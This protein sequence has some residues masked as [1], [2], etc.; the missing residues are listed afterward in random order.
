MGTM[1]EDV[2]RS[3][4][5][6]RG[7]TIIPQLLTPVE[8]QQL[9]DVCLAYFERNAIYL[10]CGI[11]QPDA[12][13]KIPEI[14]W[15]LGDERIRRIFQRYCGAPLVYC[16]HSD[17]HLNKYTG[18]HKDACGRDDFRSDAQESYGVYKMAFYL[19]A[20][21]A[22]RPALSVRAGSHLSSEI[23]TGELVRVCPQPGD[24]ILFDCRI[25]HAG[26]DLSTAAKVVRSVIRSQRLRSQF[27]GGLRRLRREPDKLAIF[28][29]LGIP[30]R[31][32]Q[33][34]VDITVRRQLNQIGESTYTIPD[35]IAS[36]L[37]QAGLGWQ[38]VHF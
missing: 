37:K 2:S 36:V 23:H 29:T 28:F 5:Q 35:G 33:E 17:V 10:D 21:S 1:S 32:L 13:R 12:F 14:R 27:F 9:R 30:N 7:F 4:F 22:D 34:H 11:T 19:Q 25:S 38:E 18:W 20:H 6:A 16:H 31:F 8:I 26:E 24:A 3:A 15:L